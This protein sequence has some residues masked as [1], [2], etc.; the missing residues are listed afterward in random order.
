MSDFLQ[1]MAKLSE[2]RAASARIRA[3]DL[4]CPITGLALQDFDIIAEIK[5]RSPS[6]GELASVAFSLDEQARAY[7]R[8]G[9][10]A[11]SVLTEPSRFGG[12]LAHI[13][14]VADRI[15]GQGVPVMRK[16]FLV[17]PV[18]VLEARAAGASGVLLIAAMLNEQELGNM[19]ACAWE[20]SMFVLLESFD[21]VDLR[22]ATKLLQRERNLD[23]AAAGQLLFGVNTRNLRDLEVDQTRLLRLAH[24]LPR[25]VVCVAESGLHSAEDAADVASWGYRAA[26]VGTALMKCENPGHLLAQMLA[27][28]RERVA[29]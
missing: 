17:K 20:H 18:Q 2:E 9:A 8:N 6:E 1:Q 25:E 29:A 11:I 19:L 26:L 15:A 12:E 3:E 27:A 10:A 13:R 14:Q 22:R 24:D 5:T 7:A 21:S 16:D 28:G 4:D 23:K